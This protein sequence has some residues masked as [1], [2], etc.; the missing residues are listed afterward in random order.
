MA[1]LFDLNPSHIALVLDRRDG[2]CFST[3]SKV[4]DV[5]KTGQLLV[6]DG[7]GR[8]FLSPACGLVKDVTI[9]D[10]NA[11]IVIELST[12]ETHIVLPIFRS[13]SSA[14]STVKY[15]NEVGLLSA[16]R[17]RPFDITPRLDE[18]PQSIFIEIPYWYPYTNECKAALQRS[19]ILLRCLCNQT[20]NIVKTHPAKFENI[21]DQV[22]II[23][24]KKNV[25][26]TRIIERF[27]SLNGTNPGIW[28]IHIEDVVGIAHLLNTRT[29]PT[30]MTI[31]LKGNGLTYQ[32][33]LNVRKGWPIAKLSTL[34]HPDK[35]VQIN[36]CN[37]HIQS[38]GQYLGSHQR[39]LETNSYINL[40]HV[41][42][43]L[44]RAR[45]KHKPLVFFKNCLIYVKRI[46]E[47]NLPQF[48]RNRPLLKDRFK[49]WLLWR[50][51]KKQKATDK[52]HLVWSLSLNELS[53]KKI[54]DYHTIHPLQTLVEKKI[55][56]LIEEN[57]LF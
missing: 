35:I 49:Y 14:N 3:S 48:V 12:I 24:S 17:K 33:I 44:K 18:I 40:P 30:S 5:V 29:Y 54:P 27:H 34:F 7:S 45:W 19:L 37:G 4:N 23:H 36:D 42:Q 41:L 32:G 1:I 43:K 9:T 28:T 55:F 2:Y 51:L 26:M 21:S 50:A 52:F 11:S 38:I 53:F 57:N 8:R 25:S 6:I 31:Y 39:Y 15:L 20:I 46:F 47:I 22:R 56:S 13:D 10:Y 16:F